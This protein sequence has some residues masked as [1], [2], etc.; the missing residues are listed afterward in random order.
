[1]SLDILILKKQQFFKFQKI[2]QS[3]PKVT[4]RV[5]N[6]KD[7]NIKILFFYSPIPWHV[8]RPI[9]DAKKKRQF[10]FIHD[11]YI[12]FIHTCGNFDDWP[13]KVTPNAIKVTPSA[14]KVTPFDGTGNFDRSLIQNIFKKIDHR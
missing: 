3:Y 9:K 10:I 5:T 4:I 1:M 8:F 2:D 6:I 7:I 14:I 13:I 12:N 11:N